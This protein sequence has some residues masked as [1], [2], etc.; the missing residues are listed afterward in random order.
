MKNLSVCLVAFLLLGVLLVNGCTPE[1]TEDELLQS[2]TKKFREDEFDKALDE[3]DL[4]LKKFPRSQ[5]AP[6]AL[7]AMA[8]I[9]AN[10]KKEYSKAESVY[11]KLAMDYPDHATAPSAAYQRALIFAQHLKKPDSAIVA[12]EYFL[13]RYPTTLS[14]SAAQSELNEL[15]K[16]AKPSK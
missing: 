3:F 1:P 16:P 7:Y 12:Y 15:R 9:Y 6:E 5:N 10:K 11:T 2:A 13:K 14:A 8:V 4:F